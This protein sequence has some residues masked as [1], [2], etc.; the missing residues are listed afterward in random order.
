M[1]RK[2]RY[3]MPYTILRYSILAAVMIVVLTGSLFLITL[4]DPYSIFGRVM[5]Y[6]VKPLVVQGNNVVAKVLS[7][8]DIYTIYKVQLKSIQATVYIIPVAFLFLVGYLSF[9]KGRL[10]CNTVCPV[11]TFLGLIS[12]VS[13]FRIKIDN[14]SCTRCGRCAVACKSSCIDFLNVSVDVSRC[15]TCFNCIE[16][17]KDDAISFG[18]RPAVGKASGDDKIDTDKRKFIFNTL[19]LGTFVAGAAYGQDEPD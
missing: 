10:Y 13:L 17:C 19:F 5:T 6:F 9:K 16:S 15:V 3:E 8:F 1:N 2:F 11:G 18:F 12:K 4:L 14:S 7:G